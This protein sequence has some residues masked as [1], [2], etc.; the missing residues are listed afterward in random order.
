MWLS[1]VAAIEKFGRNELFRDK[2]VSVIE[3]QLHKM[4]NFSYY[5]YKQYE[6][7]WID[8]V[9]IYQLHVGTYKNELVQHYG[10]QVEVAS[11]IWYG[12]MK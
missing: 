6:K 10:I 12:S 2:D 7:W 4:N 1:R 11:W 5:L 8:R 3:R 9:N